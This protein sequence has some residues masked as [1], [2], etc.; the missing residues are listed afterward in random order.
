MISPLKYKEMDQ[1]EG[2]KPIISC[3][4]LHAK[5]ISQGSCSCTSLSSQLLGSNMAAVVSGGPECD[6]LSYNLEFRAA[7][8]LLGDRFKH[9]CIVKCNKSMFPTS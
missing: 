3:S 4:Y 2:L 7:F 6:L 1:E 9:G 5:T 8:E